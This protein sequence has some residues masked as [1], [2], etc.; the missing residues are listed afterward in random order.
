MKQHFHFI[1]V[2]GVG[3]GA[4]ALLLAAKG[5]KVSGSDIKESDFTDKLKEQGAKIHIGH[6]AANI[7]CAN[8]IV[9]SSAISQDN[10]ELSWARKKGIRVLQRAELLAQLMENQKGI[11]VAGAHGKTTTASMISYLV[12]KAGLKPTTAVGGIINGGSY[13]AELGDGRYFIAEVDESDG[14]FLYFYPYYSVI[15]NID[16]EHIDYYHNWDNILSAYRKFIGQTNPAGC[17]IG[18]GEDGRLRK[19]LKESGR[20]FISYGF[21]QDNDIFAK[22]I[23]C[24]GFSSDF[25]CV[26]RAES[27]GAFHLRVPGRHNILNALAAIALGLE[28]S[29]DH[30]VIQQALSEFSGAKRRFQLKGEVCDVM[31]V[32]DYAHHPSEI[33]ATLQAAKSFGRKRVVV[34]FQPHRYSRTKFLMEEFVQAL[35]LCDYLVLTDIYAASEKAMSGVT[36]EG[37]YEKIKGQAAV[38]AV[39]LKKED[40]VRHLQDILEPGDLIL[41]LGAGDITKISDELVVRFKEEFSKIY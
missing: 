2:G 34:V 12:I 19:L 32:D 39:Y 18:W 30:A 21:L 7:G 17:V 10:P 1:G 40:I 20:K 38:P 28:L 8:T 26:R 37:L 16:F 35:C 24:R 36:S 23:T 29:I 3:M 33:T 27:L 22:N 6:D 41:T 25:E 14:S 13:H 11:T 5:F 4:L 9:Y 31:I 15:T